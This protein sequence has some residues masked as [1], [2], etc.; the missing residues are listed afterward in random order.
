MQQIAPGHEYSDI[1]YVDIS[2][3]QPA[4]T[5]TKYGMCREAAEQRAKAQGLMGVAE[6][7]A[8]LTAELAAAR[9]L[10]TQAQ[11]RAAALEAALEE[12]DAN[13]EAEQLLRAR[14]WPRQCTV[15]PCAVVP[16]D[17][18]RMPLHCGNS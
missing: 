2:D 3:I 5:L 18:Q 9:E 10:G 7:N 1:V 15:S 13:A 4:R 11:E 16:P 14:V 6:R 12:R 8:A 17:Y